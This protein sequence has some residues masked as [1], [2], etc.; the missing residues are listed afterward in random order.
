MNSMA[1][2]LVTNSYH[3]QTGTPSELRVDAWS[4][5]S[6]PFEPKEPRMK[7]FRRELAQAVKRLPSHKH[8]ILHSIYEFAGHNPSDIE[9]V[10]FY[11]IDQTYFSTLSLYGL[12]WERGYRFTKPPPLS[13]LSPHHYVY[14]IVKQSDP[15]LHWHVGEIWARWWVTLPNTKILEHPSFLWQFLKSSGLPILFVEP[16]P[17]HNYRIR[18]FIDLPRSG[19]Q[20]LLLSKTKAIIDGLIATLN[21]HDGSDESE[22]C[23]RLA[24]RTGVSPYEIAR[25][26]KVQEGALFGRNRLI[27]LWRDTVQ[28]NPQDDRCLVGEVLIRLNNQ[29][30]ELTLISEVFEIQL[31]NI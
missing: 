11:N 3:I 24:Q 28:W 18:V 16:K 30:S 14:S 12:R 9:N 20:R 6:I 23:R 19:N 31:T 22:V 17:R 29:E 2:K 4:T 1:N 26:L 25:L 27:K 7:D 5:R 10:L 15:L 21:Y 8:A 13:L